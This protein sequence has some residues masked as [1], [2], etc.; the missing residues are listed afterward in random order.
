MSDNYI[1]NHALNLGGS[2]SVRYLVDTMAIVKQ[3]QTSYDTVAVIVL[4]QGG[5]AAL[6]NALQSQPDGAIIVELPVSVD[7]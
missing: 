2:Y 6:Y 1:I 7:R 4:S 3:L 5:K